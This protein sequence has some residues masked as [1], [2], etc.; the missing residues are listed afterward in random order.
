[1]GPDS[2][3]NVNGYKIVQ[4]KQTNQNKNPEAM[5]TDQ[6]GLVF[7][8]LHYNYYYIILYI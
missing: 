4:T 8:K 2:I 6:N 5:A 7:L 3:P 1:M